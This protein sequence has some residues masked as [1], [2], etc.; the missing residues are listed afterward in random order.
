MNSKSKAKPIATSKCKWPCK[1]Q[2]YVLVAMLI[3]TFHNLFTIPTTT[4]PPSHMCTRIVVVKKTLPTSHMLTR[5]QVQRQKRVQARVAGRWYLRLNKVK[6]NNGKK[7]VYVFVF[8]ESHIHTHTLC[9]SRAN[10]FIIVAFAINAAAAVATTHT[11]NCCQLPP[12]ANYTYRF[13]LFVVY[14]SQSYFL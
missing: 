4:F 14:Y 7:C 9:M 5:A 1:V 8:Q 10:G 12:A 6:A 2:L 11:Q 3:F 13:C